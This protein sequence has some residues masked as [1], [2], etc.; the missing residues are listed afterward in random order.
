MKY[1]RTNTVRNVSVTCSVLVLGA[2]LFTVPARA[3]DD[4]AA[5]PNAGITGPVLTAADVQAVV[6]KVAASVGLPFT[7]AVTD[8][9][10]DVLAVYQ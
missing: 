10:G 4:P 5:D 3:D 6:Q 9:Q 8:R 2:L 1:L 7:I